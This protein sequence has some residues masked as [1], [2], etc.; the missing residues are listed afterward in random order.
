MLPR[1]VR[2]VTQGRVVAR[3][4]IIA[5]LAGASCLAQGASAPIVDSRVLTY[6]V[7]GETVEEIKRSIADNAPSRNG[8]SYYAGLTKWNLAATYDLIPTHQGCLLD[9]AEVYLTLRIHLPVLAQKPRSAAL[10]REWRRFFN[11]LNAHEALHGQ[12]AHRA[13]TTLLAKISGKRTDVPCSRAKLIAEQA[14]QTLIER[15]SAYDKDLD[16][17]THHGA[18][19]GAILNPSVQ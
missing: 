9:N 4:A 7:Y 3:L 10:E 12:N 13:A 5:L 16:A 6:P 8:N 11:S 18:T 14:T 17:R 19:Q 1:V 15:I 2:R